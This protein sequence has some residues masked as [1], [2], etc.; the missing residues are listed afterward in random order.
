MDTM[1]RHCPCAAA[2]R[3]GCSAVGSAPALGAGCR[4]FK[5]CHS[6]HVVADYV[7]FA[8]TFLLKSH[9]L[10]HAVAPP[11]PQKVPLRLRCSLVNALATLRLATNFLR[12]RVYFEIFCRYLFRYLFTSRSKV[13]FA[14]TY[15]LPAASK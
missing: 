6:D 2:E 1:K 9:R 15:F 4:R 7:S 3:T 14:P 5:S 11:F 12:V 8:T 13:N 10:T